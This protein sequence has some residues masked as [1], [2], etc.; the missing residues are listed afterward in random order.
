MAYDGQ[1]IAVAAEQGLFFFDRS[2]TALYRCDSPLPPRRD[3]VQEPYF[4]DGGRTLAL[5]DGRN[6]VLYRYQLP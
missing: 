6:P 4:L 3:S 5:F 1:R 2:G